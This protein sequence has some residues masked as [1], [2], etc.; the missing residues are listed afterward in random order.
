MR[1][2]FQVVECFSAL[3]NV[4]VAYK[5]LTFQ[6]NVLVHNNVAVRSLFQ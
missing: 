3:A 4:F 1:L 6:E 2:V 5:V